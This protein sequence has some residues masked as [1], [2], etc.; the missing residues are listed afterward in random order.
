METLPPDIIRVFLTLLRYDALALGLT[1]KWLYSIYTAKRD[2]NKL[3]AKRF[4]R[5]EKA[6]VRCSNEQSYG[7]V[8][9]RMEI[10]GFLGGMSTDWTV[11]CFSLKGMHTNDLTVWI[12]FD[13]TTKY[14]MNIGKIIE[15]NNLIESIWTVSTIKYRDDF[16]N[17]YKSSFVIKMQYLLNECIEDSN[18]GLGYDMRGKNH[19]V[20]IEKD[21]VKNNMI[22]VQYDTEWGGWNWWLRKKY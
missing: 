5:V 1:C 15:R 7:I 9:D 18:D 3:I 16:N 8:F 22:D 17:N 20:P 4:Q 19:W 2:A 13:H 21:I 12:E 10:F 11:K 6:Y 14:Y